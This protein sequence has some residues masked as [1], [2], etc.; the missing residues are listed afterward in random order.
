MKSTDIPKWLE[1]M[2]HGAIGEARSKAFL[3]DRFWILERS[4]DID[5]ADLIIQRK[6][7]GAN[8]LDKEPPRLGVVQVK[9]YSDKNTTQYIHKEYIIDEEGLTRNEFFLM[10]HSGIE[11]N[12]QAYLLSAKEIVDNFEL[13][14]KGHSREG[15][16]VIPGLKILSS[17]QFLISSSRPVLDRI[18]RALNQATFVKN[19]RF[20]S[21]AL[22]SISLKNEQILPVY[23]EPLDNWWG[24]IPEAFGEMKEKAKGFLFE[25]EDVYSQF[26]EIIE[27][28]DPERA[29][30]I[31][32]E[33]DAT[34]RGGNRL[35]L[36]LPE[37]Y[38]KD[39]QAVVYE[40]KNKCTI[41]KKLGILDLFIEFESAVLEFVGQDLGPK[42]E[43]LDKHT[44]YELNIKYDLKTLKIHSIKSKYI[45]DEKYWKDQN[46]AS[47]SEQS[48]RR[49]AA[50][51]K[52]LED[53]EVIV[54]WE[55]DRFSYADK[56]EGQS[57][58]EYFR[59]S[60]ISPISDLMQ[61]IYETV[62]KGMSTDSR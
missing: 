55:P 34:Y 18:E 46:K 59:H 50:G 4:V 10:C 11:A 36:I 20:L 31:A 53:G 32:E 44:V 47:R 25:M 19:R 43:S 60:R 48:G 40:H 14:P 6:I 45:P 27:S 23:L 17:N 42:K 1:R 16:Y 58:E 33:I 8:L 26:K 37:L 22:P 35:C 52:I 13:A 54:Y 29:L 3:I 12:I 49:E 51:L 38:D 41:L 30:E 21:W 24:N 5:G 15:R 56:V 39:F 28:N 61:E 62:L 7:T 2:D 9:F 57:W